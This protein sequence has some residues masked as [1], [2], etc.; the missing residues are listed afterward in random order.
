MKKLGLV[1]LVCFSSVTAFS[2]KYVDDQ[3][4]WSF[5]DRGYLGLG[6]GGL[7]LGRSNVYGNYFSI[8]VTPLVGY[9]LTKKSFDRAGF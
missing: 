3:T 2:Q 4:G 8:G 5:K 7:G 9:M 6:F 1:L